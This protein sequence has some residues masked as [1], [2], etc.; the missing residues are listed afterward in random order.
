[1][2]RIIVKKVGWL[3]YEFVETRMVGSELYIFSNIIGA[4]INIR[5]AD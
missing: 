3:I 4:F 1:M 5:L 2:G